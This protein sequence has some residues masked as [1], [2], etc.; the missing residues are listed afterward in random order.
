MSLNNNNLTTKDVYRKNFK[1]TSP[2]VFLS[3]VKTRFGSDLCTR[4]S[5]SDF[6]LSEHDIES[7]RCTFSI[8]EA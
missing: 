2:A 5:E 8:V 1:K 7:G 3:K 4:P 6:G